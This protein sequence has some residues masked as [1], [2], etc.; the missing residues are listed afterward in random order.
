MP[1]VAHE[2]SVPARPRLLFFYGERDG[3]SRRVEGFLA[4]VMQR[5]KNHDTF[6][7]H[8]IETSRSAKLAQ[9]FRVDA[10]PTVLV[11]DGRR[12]RAR[13]VRPTGCA[14]LKLALAP[15]LR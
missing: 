13:L 11:L 8:R 6:E 1:D 15:W 14:D 5:R 9:R 3:H 4:Q 12:V 10:V 7:V 2:A